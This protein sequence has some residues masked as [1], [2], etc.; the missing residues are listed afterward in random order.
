MEEAVKMIDPRIS[1]LAQNLV[2]YS[3]RVQPNENVL[4][5]AIGLEVPLVKELIK[6]VYRAQ[7]VPFVSIKDKAVDRALL[8]EATVEQLQMM[9]K[10]EGER[11]REMQAYIGVRSGDNAAEM[12]DVPAEKMDLYIRYFSQE[13]HTKF[14][15]LR[16]NGWS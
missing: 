9:A 11:M 5:E 6:E 15:W 4:I 2:N 10:Y 14:G 13:V 8:M 3:C 1:K 12:S 7:G 16:P